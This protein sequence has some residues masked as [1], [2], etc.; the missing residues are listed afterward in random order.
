MVNW[1]EMLEEDWVGHKNLQLPQKLELSIA[2]GNWSSFRV[3]PLVPMHISETTACF[4]Q[5]TGSHTILKVKLNLYL[6]KN[7]SVLIFLVGWVRYN[8]YHPPQKNKTKYPKS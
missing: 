4:Y 1:F 5:A 7:V 3:Q 6:I 8:P 2:V